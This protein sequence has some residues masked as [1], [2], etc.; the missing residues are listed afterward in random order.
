[1]VLSHL[2]EKYPQPF[3]ISHRDIS[4]QLQEKYPNLK[5]EDYDF[6]AEL[7]FIL[8][9]LVEDK[10]VMEEKFGPGNTRLF[11]ITFNGAYFIKYDG[12]YQ[13]L[14]NQRNA[15]SIRVE[16]LEKTTKEVQK[17]NLWLTILVAAGTLFQAAYSLTKLY[18]EHDWLWYFF[19]P[20]R[21][22]GL[23]IAILIILILIPCSVFLY[24]K[25]K[26]RKTE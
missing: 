21:Q 11:A 5:S 16:N 4:Q 13:E 1:M 10:Y 8:Q 20:D 3:A 15:E 12:G 6:T 17:W 23:W 22:T 26:S 25:I 7:F 2:A 18:W 24:R 14:E 9:K 19:P